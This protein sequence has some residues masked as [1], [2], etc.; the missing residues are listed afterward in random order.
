MHYAVA[1]VAVL[2]PE[3][4]EQCFDSSRRLSNELRQSGQ[5]GHRNILH[6]SLLEMGHVKVCLLGST[7]VD[8][9]ALLAWV[10][11]AA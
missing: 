1:D 11:V 3:P 5:C 9:G 10:D 7:E 4:P 8:D 2:S 6:L